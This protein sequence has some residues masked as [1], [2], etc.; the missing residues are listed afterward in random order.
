MNHY[1]GSL[2]EHYHDQLGDNRIWVRWFLFIGGRWLTAILAIATLADIM[3]PSQ[4]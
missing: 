3:I 2:I 1:S 4:D